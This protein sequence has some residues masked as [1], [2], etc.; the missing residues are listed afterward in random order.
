[1]RACIVC[2]KDEPNH[3]CSKKVE[4][5]HQAAQTRA[6]NEENFEYAQEVRQTPAAHR[7]FYGLA[8]MER[9]S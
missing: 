9:N 8:Q 7:L 4:A 2:G 1:M 6:L 3:K 5:A